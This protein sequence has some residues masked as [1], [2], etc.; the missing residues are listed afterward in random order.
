[1][2]DL[3]CD[4]LNNARLNRERIQRG[5]SNQYYLE[6]AHAV[7]QWHLGEPAPQGVVLGSLPFV[8]KVRP[9]TEE[10]ED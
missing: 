4:D 6:Q 9:H 2:N 10:K 3:M 5:D 8:G 7:A 1:M